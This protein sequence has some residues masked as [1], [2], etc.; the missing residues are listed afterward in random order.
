MKLPT[1]PLPRP[2]KVKLP[3]LPPSGA[4]LESPTSDSFSKRVTKK[5]GSIW[6]VCNRVASSSS[7]VAL[8]TT[9]GSGL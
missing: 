2:F 8:T 5:G 6:L 7:A 1:F 4:G 9:I 3:D